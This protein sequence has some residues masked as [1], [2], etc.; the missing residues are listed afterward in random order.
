MRLIDA[1]ALMDGIY[2]TMRPGEALYRVPPSAIDNA[3]SVDAVPV[4]YCRECKFYSRRISTCTLKR[5]L[6]MANDE[7]FCSYGCRGEGKA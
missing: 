4:V 7:A 2:A 6:V 1:D 3:P 5:G